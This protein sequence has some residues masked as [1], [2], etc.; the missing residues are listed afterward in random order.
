MSRPL[1]GK[2]FILL[3]GLSTTGYANQNPVLLDPDTSIRQTP[4]HQHHQNPVVN[5]ITKPPVSWFFF[6]PM[7]PHEIPMRSSPQTKNG[8]V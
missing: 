8:L 4:T 1:L 2:L 7:Y 5:P 3:E 6:F